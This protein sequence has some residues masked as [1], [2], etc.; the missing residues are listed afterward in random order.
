MKINF[1]KHK[2]LRNIEEVVK[3]ILELEKLSEGLIM[4]ILK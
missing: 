3:D 2:P 1:Y 4:E